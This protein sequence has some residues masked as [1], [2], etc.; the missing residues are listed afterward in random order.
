MRSNFF[1]S[2]LLL[3]IAIISVGIIFSFLQTSKKTLVTNGLKSS[4]K[5]WQ[6]RPFDTLNRIPEWQQR[7][8]IQRSIVVLKDHKKILPFSRMDIPTAHISI[9]GSD[10]AF[11]KMYLRFG[12]LDFQKHIESLTELEQIEHQLKKHE[13]L[14]VTLHADAKDTLKFTQASIELLNH[15]LHKHPS[16]LIVFG[17]DS[18]VKQIAHNKAEAFIIAHENHPIAQEETVHILVGACPALGNLKAEITGH[19]QKGDGIHYPANG[20]L[21]FGAPESVGLQSSD[22]NEIDSIVQNA[23]NKGAFPG[24]QIA[25]CVDTQLIFQKS[26]GFH[27]YENKINVKN[28]DVYDIASVTKIA[29]STLLSMHL[30]SENKFSLDKTLGHYLS[31]LTENTPFAKVA[32]KDMM[33]HQAGF[34]P[35]IAFYKKVLIDGK[36]DPNVFSETEKEGFTTKVAE[37]IYIANSYNDSIYKQIVASKIGEK[38]YEYSDLCFYFIQKINES[39]VGEKQNTF[40][41]REFYAKMGLRR[42]G[43]LPLNRFSKNEIPP[44]ENDKI[45][46]NQLVHGYVHDQGAAMLGGIAGHAGVFSNASDLAAVMQLFLNKGKYGGQRF[47]SETTSDLYTKQQFPGNRR[48]AGFD[49]PNA[50]GGGTCDKSA[51]QSSYGHSGFTGTLAWV[52]PETKFVFVFLSNRVNPDADNWKIRDMHVR[53]EIQHV[54]Y[55]AL[56][57]RK[58]K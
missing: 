37:N 19:F 36:L 53:T 6:S 17:A 15:V 33:A 39:L 32:I 8:V 16:T 2:K 25:V 14:I 28:S 21:R 47:F 1:T 48:G 52:D 35:W 44:T 38:K 46:R 22:L 7:Q 9:G 49:R 12:N 27:T 3:F 30:H 43:Y 51:S 45:F 50:S 23:M 40:I 34:T 58:I 42:I 18:Y 56:A 54:V 41:E 55:E 29:A 20:R 13:R 24:C 5:H 4:P 26:Y 10:T 31:K 57:K 11:V